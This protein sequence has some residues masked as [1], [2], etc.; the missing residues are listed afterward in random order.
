MLLGKV[1]LS[2][3]ARV[4]AAC[5]P[6]EKHFGTRNNKIQTLLYFAIILQR[7]FILAECKLAPAQASGGV[8]LQ[9]LAE[10]AQC[11]GDIS[12]GKGDSH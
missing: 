8:F 6:H 11:L 2:A 9:S 10:A 1:F 12:F 7:R 4:N 5:K 3:C